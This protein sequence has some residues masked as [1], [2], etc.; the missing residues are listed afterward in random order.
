MKNDPTIRL[1][2][3]CFYDPYGI[4]TVKETVENMQIFS[5]YSI[6]VM[7]F[8]EFKAPNGAFVFPPEFN[9][10]HYDGIIIHNS[11][12]YNVYN[13]I[14][15]AASLRSG[16]RD[17]PGVK[18][19]MK[20]DENYLYR[21]TAKFIGDSKFD[22][23]LTC[24]PENMLEKVYPPELA[25][26]PRFRRML[27]GY[28]TPK[29]RALKSSSERTVDIGY[30]GSIQPIGF[31]RLSYE[32]RSIGLDTAARLAG[33]PDLKL[34]ISS[35]WEDR[36]EG[37]AWFGFL[38]NCKAI[39]GVESGASIFDWDGKTEKII[40]RLTEELASDEEFLAALKPFESDFYNQIS[41]R[42]FEAAATKT[43]Q[44]MF[45]G[46]YSG[47]F[48]PGRHFFE[49]KRDFSNLDEAVAL[50]KD[51]KR[52][53]EMVN[54]AYRE[55]IQN[56]RWHIETFVAEVDQL[57]GEILVEKGV[58]TPPSLT[59]DAH[60]KNIFYLAAHRPYLDP[61]FEWM[62][63][64][65][66]AGMRVFSVGTSN[67]LVE[68]P[69]EEQLKKGVVELTEPEKH[70]TTDEFLQRWDL[71]PGADDAIQCACQCLYEIENLQTLSDEKLAARLNAPLHSP[72][73]GDFRWLLDYVL[74]KS[75]SLGNLLLR[76][77]G[78]A[79]I[80]AADM[81]TMIPALIAGSRW[82]VPVFYDAHEFW[83][84]VSATAYEFEK[85]FWMNFEKRLCRHAA[86]RVTV[87]LPLAD[88]MTRAYG[89][90][91]GC[92]PNCV[93]RA[94]GNKAKA[95]PAKTPAASR[96]KS[97]APA[98][99]R[100]IFQGQFAP[101]RGIDELIRLWEQTTDQS[102]L[103]LRGPDNPH[104]ERLLELAESSGLLNKRIFFPAPVSEDKLVSALDEFDVAVI[105][106]PAVGV[107]YANCCPN[108][109]S[110]Y[111][112]AG[113]PILANQTAFVDQ[114]LHEADAGFCVNF[115]SQNLFLDRVRTLTEDAERR[116]QMGENSRAY[117]RNSYNWE[118]RAAP[119]YQEV[120][121]R[122]GPPAPLELLPYPDREALFL[123]P[124][125]KTEEQ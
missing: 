69:L 91:F 40:D 125:E 71:D 108:K 79:G 43:M 107:S 77:R 51:D 67:E 46:T 93:P 60:V 83:P 26:R 5:R 73:L 62:S 99:C 64:C 92:L 18:V 24:L 66:P 2:L 28:V 35:E 55:I 112:A 119:F 16:L 19:I 76:T 114:V 65:A 72:R 97:A 68:T 10:R 33:R 57:I 48:I 95:G 13:L 90:E 45:P 103:Y 106:Y 120:M 80:I 11:F 96:K 49:L 117:Y 111:M 6:T 122:S 15:M 27:T 56:P 105:P 42:H 123:P 41:P 87:S 74:K 34:D 78:L 9:L 23:V 102:L 30:R 113:L 4:S 39:L 1:L 36:F 98:S 54:T 121:A 70:E 116:R 21:E 101:H 59:L 81:D 52:R 115:K 89:C 82:G 17:Y 8:F 100:F 25:G 53:N 20:Q 37:D 38:G 14:P 75:F 47:I 104:K 109:L 63:G 61:R 7:N 22:L 84:E 29:L 118:T 94:D 88:Y 50:L 44:I 124:E 86:I 58:T 110:Q 12:A 32:K 31:G 85:V 3:V